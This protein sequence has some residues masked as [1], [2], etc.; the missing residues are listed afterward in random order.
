VTAVT[1]D[2]LHD[3]GHTLQLLLARQRSTE[4]AAQ[5]LQEVVDLAV[6]TVPGARTAGVTMLGAD[7]GFDSVAV[8]DPAVREVDRLQH[9]L[10]EGPCLD[11]I[12]KEPIV[13]LSD[14]AHESRWP[15]FA[16]AAGELGV[17]SMLACRLTTSDG[18]VAS[19][20][21]HSCEP[22]AFDR[23]A[24]LLAAVSSAHASVALAAA[25]VNASLR[26]AIRSRQS[27]GEA[28][29]MLMERHGLTSEQAFELLVKT[30]QR[31]NMKLRDVAD[32]ILATRRDPGTTALS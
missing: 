5:T 20:N 28:C 22:D 17:R 3:I 7:G 13:T 24:V 29:G 26:A 30:S 9:D 15:A 19:L 25:N 18:T 2:P 21:L 11:A 10:R 23:Q 6:V 27:I 4:T 12:V 8:T 16:A 32:H 1:N 14:M 31:L